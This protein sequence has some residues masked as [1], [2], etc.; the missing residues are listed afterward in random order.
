MGRPIK[1]SGREG[2][3]LRAIG[4]GLGVSG[5]DLVERLQMDQ[6][7]LVDVLN[8]LIGLGYVEVTSMKQV[9]TLDDFAA[10]NFEV[11]PSFVNELKEA[12][13]RQ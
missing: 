4:Y 10:E 3:V 2:S 13:K 11:N 6:E 9:V 7:E 1:V 5:T 12:L 8:A